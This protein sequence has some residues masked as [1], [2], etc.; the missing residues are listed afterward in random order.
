MIASCLLL[1]CLAVGDEGET[2]K[3]V[4]ATKKGAAVLDIYLSNEIKALYH[5]L[6]QGND[7]Y[8][9]TLNQTNVENNNNKFYII[10]V[11]GDSPFVASYAS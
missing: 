1:K 10:Q 9:A 2:E 6:Q 7:I 4:T 8:D 11:L 5:V 3:L